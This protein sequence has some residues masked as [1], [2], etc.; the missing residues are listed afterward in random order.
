MSAAGPVVDLYVGVDGGATKTLLRLQ[1]AA[2]L[3]LGEGHGGPANIRLS[4]EESWHSIRAALAQALFAA[5]LQ[6]DSSRYRI[7]CGAGLAGTEVAAACEHFL[8][9]ANPFARLVLRSDGYT[10]CLGA[11]GGNDGAVIAVGTGT[12]GFQIESG[13]ESRVGGWGFPQ[14]DEGG[15][16]WLGL[17]AMRKTLHWLDGRGPADPL[18]A[19]I[20]ARFDGDLSQLVAWAND[21]GGTE[22]AQLAPLVVEYVARETPLALALVREAAGELD[23]I[24]R[25]LDAK[26]QRPL[27]C[28]ILGGLGAFFETMARAGAARATRARAV[29]HACRCTAHGARRRGGSRTRRRPGTVAA[30]WESVLMAPN[31]YQAWVESFVTD[32]RAGEAIGTAEKSVRALAQPSAQT[33]KVVVFAPHPDDEMMTGGLPLRLLR[34]RQCAVVVV[35]VTLGSRVDRRAARWRELQTACS[36]IGFGAATPNR[37]GLEGITLAGRERDPAGWAAAVDSVVAVLAAEQPQIVFLPHATDWNGTHVGVHHLVVEAMRRLPALVCQAV[38]TEYWFSM[39]APNLMVESTPSDVADL[40]AALSLHVGEVSRNPYHLRLPAGMIDSVRRGAELVG[41]QGGAA[42]Q[43]GFATLYRLRGWKAG[44][45]HDV[46][47]GGRSVAAGESLEQLFPADGG[48]AA[49]K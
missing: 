12:I 40:I 33:P 41:G 11:H 37:A 21:A 28:S 6:A 15:G 20:Q 45:F 48:V 32:L 39:A 34:E 8:A 19:A 31:P 27:P 14:G 26:S 35:A 38:E 44:Q 46:L 29:R 36:Y 23:R 49:W 7:S 30:R 43:F 18:L 2:G 1:D 13:R 9:A 4:V 24:G 22:F 25:A 47:D 42:P 3:T 5:G 16:A 17:E 10:S